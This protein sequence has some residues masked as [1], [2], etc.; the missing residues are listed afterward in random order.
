MPAHPLW[1]K[2]VP[3]A[4]ILL[5][6]SPAP[7]QQAQDQPVGEP[8]PSRQARQVV[9][10]EY[11]ILTP[12]GTVVLE[13][14]LEYQHSDF[15]RFVAGG[16]VVLDTVLVGQVEAT[17]ADRD[18]LTA[19]LAARTGL[20]E[21]A[22]IMVKVPYVYRNDTTT[23]TVAAVDS[24]TVE[25]SLDSNDLGDVE[26]GMRFQV[27]PTRRDRPILIAGA[28]LRT[29]TGQGPFDVRRDDAGIEEELA[30]GAGS[31]GVEPNVTMLMISDPAVYYFN[32]A[33]Q[34]N[35]EE[36]VGK[37]VGDTLIE[38]FDPGDAIRVGFGLGLALNEKASFNIGYSHDFYTKTEINGEETSRLSIG[39]LSLGVNYVMSRNTSMDVGVAIG[40]T[41][42][43]PDVRLAVRVPIAFEVF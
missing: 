16:A 37:T 24:E 2:V 6:A 11:G 18:S 19:S 20:G 25:R 1:Q 14:G 17:Q 3:A 12:P 4:A 5:A 28:R 33:Y 41:D 31:W 30:T 43:A 38:D 23:T 42:D 34:W 10:S 32:A 7:A 27:T 15:N 9:P 21:R 13:P 35:L 29:P 39:T 40:V 8:P 22:E 26:V 36:D